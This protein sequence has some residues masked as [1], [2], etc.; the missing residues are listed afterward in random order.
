MEGDQKNKFM[1]QRGTTLK[2]IDNTGA[3]KIKCIGI[4]GHSKIRYA[5]LGD[6]IVA[7]VK[8]AEPRQK[9]KKGDIVYA[10]IVRQR[11]PYQIDK[12]GIYLKFDDNAAILIDKDSKKPLGKRFDGPIPRILKEKGFGEVVNLAKNTV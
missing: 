12:T 3:K 2:V 5:F 11:K 4:P 8:D 7:S 9:I 6:I 1:I 10:L